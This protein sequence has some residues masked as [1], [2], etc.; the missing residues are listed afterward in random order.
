LGRHS[1]L[2]AG[3]LSDMLLGVQDM[4]GSLQLRK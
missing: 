1:I 3:L 2:I 4:E